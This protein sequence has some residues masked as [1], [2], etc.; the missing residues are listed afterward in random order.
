MAGISSNAD[1]AGSVVAF[2]WISDVGFVSAYIQTST[3]V[4]VP[5]AWSSDVVVLVSAKEFQLL[6]EISFWLAIICWVLS[7]AV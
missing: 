4:K 2:T 7:D 1:L 5:V 6:R 3:L